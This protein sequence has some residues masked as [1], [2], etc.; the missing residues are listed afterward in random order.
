MYMANI[1]IAYDAL[2]VWGL[3]VKI[4]YMGD[5]K[6]KFSGGLFASLTQPFRIA[7]PFQPSRASESKTVGRNFFPLYQLN[8]SP[9]GWNSCGLTE[10]MNQWIN[11]T[12]DC[13][14]APATPGLINM[15]CLSLILIFLGLIF[16]LE[17][18]IRSTLFKPRK[19]MIQKLNQSDCLLACHVSGRWMGRKPG[20]SH[21]DTVSPSWGR[22]RLLWRSDKMR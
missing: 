14:T 1:V 18:R 19:P 15:I 7:S 12:C 8:N 17:P 6:W 5:E 20:W 3:T 4:L 2:V 10:W 16:C 13:R 11:D 22:R 21:Q 9:S